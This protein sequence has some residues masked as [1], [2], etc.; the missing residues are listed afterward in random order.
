MTQLLISF[1]STQCRVFA[2]VKS[3]CLASLKRRENPRMDANGKNSS[4][5][6][7]EKATH[8]LLPCDISL[9][10]CWPRAVLG[11]RGR[12]G[13]GGYFRET[14]C[15]QQP[16]W[17]DATEDGR[18]ERRSSCKREGLRSRTKTSN[19]HTS[20]LLLTG[21][22]QV[23]QQILNTSLKLKPIDLTVLVNFWYYIYFR[24]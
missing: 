13:G 17:A 24:P 10:V 11:G 3:L 12:G 4:G 2:R 18:S 7:W 19:L 6:L 9:S 20:Q 21:E 14:C 22:K 1:N 5:E 16:H 15:P 23:V 8:Y